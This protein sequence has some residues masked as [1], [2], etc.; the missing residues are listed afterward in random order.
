MAGISAKRAKTAQTAL[1]AIFFT[2]GFA[3]MSTLP[4]I[5]EI[6]QQIHVVFAEWGLIIGLSGIGSLL[7]LAFTNKLVSRFGTSIV[8][9][10]SALGI[11]LTLFSI[12]WITNS[13]LMFFVYLAQA[14]MFSTFNIALNAQAVAFQKKLGRVLL[15]TLHG[16]WSVGAALTTTFTGWLISFA[17]DFKIQM[18]IVPVFCLVVFQIAGSKLLT[19]EEERSGADS[20]PGKKV[21]WLKSPTYLWLLAIGLFAGMWPELVVMDWSSLFVRKIYGNEYTSLAGVPYAV[22]G[23]AMVIGRFSIASLTKRYHLA[24]LAKWG[25]IFGSIAMGIGVLGSLIPGGF[26]IQCIF[27]GLAGFGLAPQVP[28]SYSAA[29]N[30][31]GLSTAQALSRISLVNA[32]VV[33]IAKVFMGG[34]AQG[35]GLQW[36]FVFPITMFFIAGLVSSVVANHSKRQASEDATAYPPTG[37]ISSI[38]A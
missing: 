37:P 10:L 29:G 13:A 16:A 31:R 38:D 35:F 17:L 18:V 36:A 7:P 27:F 21:S 1:L 5:P 25:G 33:M 14:L 20:K 9:R 28:S 4:R 15:G 3:A 26:V 24:T 22:L 12:P 11:T 8:I 34:L 23:A 32:L 19:F 2:Q 6:L 30:V